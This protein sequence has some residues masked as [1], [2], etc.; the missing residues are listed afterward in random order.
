VVRTTPRGG[1]AGQAPAIAASNVPAIASA[2]AAGDAIS[3]TAAGIT[4]PD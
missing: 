2:P 1:T 3:Y 4:V